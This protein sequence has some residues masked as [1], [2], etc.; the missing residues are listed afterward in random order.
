MK[1]CEATKVECG[2]PADKI[3]FH[4]PNKTWISH[5]HTHTYIYMVLGFE[6][7]ASSLLGRCYISWATLPALFVLV[8]FEIRCHF[9][10]RL[11]WIWGAIF[12]FVLACITG[13]QVHATIPAIGWDEGG[14]LVW[15]KL[16]SSWSP[17]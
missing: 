2:W 14:L 9:M 11:T 17:K 12:L 6:L 13:W 8:I 16:Q 5:R 10:L 15:L 1:A 3:Q 4:M 7:R